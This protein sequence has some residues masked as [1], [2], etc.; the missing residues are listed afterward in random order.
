MP[1]AAQQSLGILSSDGLAPTDRTW[2]TLLSRGGRGVL[3]LRTSPTDRLKMETRYDQLRDAARTFHSQH[4]EV[5]ELFKRFTF[6]RID[7]GFAHYSVNAIF[8]R[9][10]WETDQARTDP[11][12]S[13]KLNNNHRPFYARAF[14]KHYPEHE[15]FFRLREQISRD[16]PAVNLPPLG[17][18]DFPELR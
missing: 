5:W 9:I 3:F 17:P 8:E 13:F 12:I 1:K 15:G 4:P 16:G 11:T 10:R 7:R 14:M 18:K 6:D 2:K